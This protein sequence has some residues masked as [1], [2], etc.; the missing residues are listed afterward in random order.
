M[1]LWAL[2]SD[3]NDSWVAIH[4]S[5]RRED[6]VLHAILAHHVHEDESARHVV[7]V[8]LQWLLNRLTHSL[9]TC[10]MDNGINLVL[11]ENLVESLSIAHV[12]LIERN[13][14]ADNLGNTAKRLRV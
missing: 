4:G 14:L 11:L 7:V 6:D 5:G 12:S 3:R 8:V 13:L 10:E 9:Q 1:S 2:L